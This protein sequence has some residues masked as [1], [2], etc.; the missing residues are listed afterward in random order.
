MNILIKK[1]GKM[2]SFPLIT[3]LYSVADDTWLQSFELNPMLLY[4]REISLVFL[5]RNESFFFF[6]FNEMKSNEK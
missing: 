6:S 4:L 5:L 3:Y 1:K 2:L